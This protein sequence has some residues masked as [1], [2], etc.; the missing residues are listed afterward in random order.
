VFLE[1]DK[2]FCQAMVQ[3]GDGAMKLKVERLRE[4]LERNG[5]LPSLLLR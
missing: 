3:T 2:P 1:A 5:K 4:E